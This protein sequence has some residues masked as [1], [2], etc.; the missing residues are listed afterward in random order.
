M[1]AAQELELIHASD[2]PL[3]TLFDYL[4][5]DLIVVFDDLLALEDR[6]TELLQICG[7]TDRLFC[8][9]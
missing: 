5:D 4:G 6:Y 9:D 1:T 3:G 7:S 8:H 2:Q